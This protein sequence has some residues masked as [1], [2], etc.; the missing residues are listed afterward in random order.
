MAVTGLAMLVMTMAIAVVR[1]AKHTLYAADRRASRTAD[2][3]A[4][5][6][7]NRAKCPVALSRALIRALVSADDNPLRIRRC[8]RQRK[9]HNGS[10][11]H[12]ASSHRKISSG[13]LS[14]INALNSEMF[15]VKK[16][17]AHRGFTATT[18]QA[19]RNAQKKRA[20]EAPA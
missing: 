2:H 7:A 1:D 10:S 11:N 14:H 12:Q 6:T 4:D 16:L 8:H 18:L 5:E 13:K 19:S 20:P 15:R 17:N 9:R 3:A